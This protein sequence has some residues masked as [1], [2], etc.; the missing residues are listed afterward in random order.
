VS[1]TAG[2][3]SD[4]EHS[5]ARD[6]SADTIVSRLTDAR[7]GDPP[8]TVVGRM[9][10][11]IWLVFI[12]IPLVDAVS[13][14][15]N[16][17]AKAVTI[18][19]TIAFVAV[20]VSIAVRRDKPLPDAQALRSVGAL[21]VISV[22]LTALDR[23]GWGTLFIF[24]VVA[25]AMCVRSPL[26]FYG[27]LLCTALC[28]GSLLAIDAALGAIF[29]FASSTLGVGTL[30]LVVADLRTRNR[31]LHTARAELARLAVAD[32]RARFA[33]DLH[34]LLGHSLSVIALKAELAGR[35][36]R[37]QPAEAAG[38]VSEIEQVARGALNEVREA[39]SGYRQPTL[40]D[41]IAGAKMALSA[42]GIE[43]RI[44]RP[45][46]TFDPAIEAVLAW[47]V[48]EGATNVIRHSGAGHCLVKVMAGL[49]EAGVEVLDDGPGCEDAIANGHG[50]HGLEGLR[51]RVAR[52]HGQIEAGTGAAGGYR[53]AVRV[54]VPAP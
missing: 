43:A 24:T 5:P 47:T 17:T 48:R 11:F 31:E 35:L 46:V 23:Q 34:D 22:A 44:E 21:L 29:G 9:R 19:A 6:R 3:E 49:G 45:A 13:S 42:A 53:L 18:V 7:L 52:L 39:V 50:G 32:E 4:R 28:V 2:S 25:V 36:M 41:E 33:R 15:N 8:R 26:N 14:H 10:M 30:M 16:G 38:H 37:E 12:A 20:F 40:D 27:V 54:P 1:Q 51:E